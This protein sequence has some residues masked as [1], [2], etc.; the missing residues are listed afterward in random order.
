MQETPIVKKRL[1]E[2]PEVIPQ[3]HTQDKRPYVEN[4]TWEHPKEREF[5]EEESEFD[6]EREARRKKRI[7]QI[8]VI[9]AA[10]FIVGILGFLVYRFIRVEELVV[11]GNAELTAEY[12]VNLSGIETGQHVFTIDMDE[13]KTGLSGDPRI[14][15][16]GME[17]HFPNR[18]ELKIVEC[19]PVARFEIDGGNSLLI[20]KNG[21]AVGVSDRAGEGLTLIEGLN[22]SEYSIGYSVRTEDTYKQKMLCEL[23]NVLAEAEYTQE[24]ERIDISLTSNLKLYNRTG[25]EIDY[26]AAE[27][28]ALKTKWMKAVLAKLSDQGITEGKL[29][30]YSEEQAIYSR[31]ENTTD[32][33]AIHLNYM[34]IDYEEDEPDEEGGQTE[35]S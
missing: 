32:S 28:F 5:L 4:D 15:Y 1:Q 35:E 11:T 34:D 7:R 31:P 13:M 19:M 14:E 10:V 6:P 2:E 30:V 16:E 26:G 3:E 27:D 21:K 23:L 25:M 12:I 22:L 17:Y 24:I 33:S 18:I 20:D 8:S 9:A 29:D